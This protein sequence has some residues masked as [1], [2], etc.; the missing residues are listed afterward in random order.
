MDESHIPETEQYDLLKT[1]A[2]RVQVNDNKFWVRW[3]RV[4]TFK[5][6]L[7]DSR[8][9]MLDEARG[10]ITFGDGCFGSTPSSGT[11]SIMV[12]YAFGGGKAGN[13]PSG[14][15]T[16]LIGS[17][18]N[19]SGVESFMPT[20]GGNEPVSID[21]LCRLGNGRIRHRFRAATVLDYES[22]IMER[23]SQVADV[24]CFSNTDE[25]E[26]YKNGYVT[27]VINPDGENTSEYEA[28][29]CTQ[30]RE[31]LSE[32][33]D[34]LVLAADRL[35]IIP[36]PSLVINAHVSVEVKSF[37]DLSDVEQDIQKAIEALCSKYKGRIGLC[38]GLGEFYAV[39]K[40]VQ[41]VSAVR[42]VILEGEYYNR[43]KIKYI[44]LDGKQE[45]PF[46]VVKSGKHAVTI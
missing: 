7:P 5:D 9:Y 13:L 1:R 33:I 32:K 39:V 44:A 46:A 16:H 34:C 42:G 29:L 14:G 41:N 18:P 28:Y 8:H 11:D 15:V 3:E 27:V 37:E 30:I 38:P 23:F 17:I 19:V 40:W 21:R 12:K 20:C 2:E 4:E 43:G 24:R 31:Y 45:Y 26:C 22:M 10:E 25:N 35:R 6:S 36:A